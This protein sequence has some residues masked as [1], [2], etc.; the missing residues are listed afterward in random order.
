MS[1][2]DHPGVPATQPL[3]GVR[4]LDLT[5]VMTGPYCTMMLGDLG[6]DVIKIEMPGR[7]D[8]T[9]AWGPPFIDGES[10]YFMSVNRNKRSVALDLKSPGGQ[11]ALWRLIDTADV[12]V[13]NFSPGT[14][15]R[16]GFGYEAVKARRPGMIYAAISGFGQFGP[17]FQRVAYDLIVQGMSGIM[18]VTGHPDGP[19]TRLGV[20]IGDIGAGMFAAFAIASSLYRRHLTGEGCFIDTSMLGGQVALLTYQAG[21]YWA[22][23]AP[24]GRVGNAHTMIAPYDT[25]QCLDGFVNIA[26]GN[27]AMWQRFCDAIERP[28]LKDHPEFATN[29]QRITGKAALYRQIEPTLM[30]LERDDIVRRLDR[31]SVPCGPIQDLHDVLNDPQVRAQHLVQQF[32]HPVVGAHNVAGAPYHFD[33]EPVTARIAAPLLGEQ[34]RA[35]L[36]EAGFSGEEIDALLASGA[37]QSPS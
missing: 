27:D 30:T 13:E 29:A 11:D 2:S 4:V 25:F 1:A 24:P 3:S 19:P 35:V 5:R 17:D 15:S 21:G 23:G 9:R 10:V 26:V 8:D 31:A 16:L 28:D 34:T 20:P 22:N 14:L 36:A 6:A 7:G 18:S 32:D 37:A 33:N 12:L